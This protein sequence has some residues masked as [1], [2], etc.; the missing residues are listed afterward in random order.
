M[1]CSRFRCEEVRTPAP[2]FGAPFP[3]L[4]MPTVAA[5]LVFVC[6]CTCMDPAAA[7]VCVAERLFAQQAAIAAIVTV[8]VTHI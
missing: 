6:Q 5:V 1:P 3:I 7:P 8:A 2:F 4:A